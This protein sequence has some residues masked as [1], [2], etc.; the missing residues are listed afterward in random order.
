GPAGQPLPIPVG[1]RVEDA[2]GQPLQGIAVELEVVAGGGSTEPAVTITDSIGLAVAQWFLGEAPGENELEARVRGVPGVA[3][4]VR[5]IGT[6]AAPARLVAVSGDDQF[7]ALGDALPNELVVRVEDAAG[8]PVPGVR[9]AFSVTVGDG[10][11]EP[12]VVTSDAAGTAKA[13]WTV[14][15]EPGVQTARAVI[16]RSG[17]AVD[18][19]AYADYRVRIEPGIVAGGTHTCLLGSAGGTWCWGANDNGQLGSGSTVRA[20]GAVSVRAPAPLAR[21]ASGVSHTCA[22]DRNG[23]AFCWGANESGQLGTGDRAPRAEPTAVAT[24]ESFVALTTGRSHTCALTGDGRAFCWGGGSSGQIGDG[25]SVD[26][27]APVAVAGDIKFSSLTAGWRHTCG[28]AADGVVYCWGSNSDGQL[29]NGTT[30]DLGRP[31]P[32][33]SDVRFANV[34]AGAAHTCAA[35]SDG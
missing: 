19:K 6:A 35:T 22:L 23:R 33:A 8:N 18:F 5:A 14:G 20:S 32:V 7:A 10:S 2:E 29:G 4:R 34:A 21:I 13:V 26:R 24:R 11:V 31:T 1:I 25:M 12:A 9:V 17:I 30:A 15:H 3:A 16:G 28:V 27:S